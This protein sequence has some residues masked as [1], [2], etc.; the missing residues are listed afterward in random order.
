MLAALWPPLTVCGQAPS[1]EE[2]IRT[3]DKDHDGKLDLQELERALAAGD[4][5]DVTFLRVVRDGK[6][7]PTSLQTAVASYRSAKG[8][9][10]VDLIGAI[11]VA[12]KAYYEQLNELFRDYDVVLYELIAPEGTRIPR[13]GQS[14]DHPVGRMQRAI[15]SMLD[16]SFQLD[17]ID[18]TAKRLAGTWRKLL[19]DSVSHDGSGGRAGGPS[20]CAQ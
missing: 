1:A 18:Y 12:D 3:F 6:G 15:K 4:R 20:E 8:N 14:S 17:E 7:E 9:L 13:G 11:H 2:W 5:S 10:Q 19:A 16:L